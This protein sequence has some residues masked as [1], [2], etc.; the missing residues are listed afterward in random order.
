MKVYVFLF[1]GACCSI[2]YNIAILKLFG[3]RQSKPPKQILRHNQVGLS[4]LES[5]LYSVNSVCRFTSRNTS[6]IAPRL[7]SH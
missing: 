2:Y 7:N 1:N 6:L 4:A 3:G 5:I